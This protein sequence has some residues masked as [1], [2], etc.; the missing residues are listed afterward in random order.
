MANELQKARIKLKRGTF[1]FTMNT[2][3][4]EFSILIVKT[5]KQCALHS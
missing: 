4:R 3:S 2:Y 1:L 5:N